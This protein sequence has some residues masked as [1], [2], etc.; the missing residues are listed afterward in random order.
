MAYLLRLPSRMRTDEIAAF[1]DAAM[2]I[3]ILKVEGDNFSSL[4]LAAS[5]AVKTGESE[6]VKVKVQNVKL[7]RRCA[8]DCFTHKLEACATLGRRGNIPRGL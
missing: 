1:G 7:R 4:S 5:S 6:S 8:G 3:A 2:D